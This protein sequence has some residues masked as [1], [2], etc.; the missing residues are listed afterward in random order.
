[1]ST[2]TSRNVLLLLTLAALAGCSMWGDDSPRTVARQEFV[3]QPGAASRPAG[4]TA[5]K[6]GTMTATDRGATT[7]PA[8]P[9]LT[10]D[11]SPRITA[12]DPQ[13][14]DKDRDLIVAGM[15]GQV[16]GQPIY[17]TD[18][19]ESMDEQLRRLGQDLRPAEFERQV[20]EAV[21]KV[22]GEIIFNAL[23]LGEAERDLSPQE[24]QGV[25]YTMQMRREEL[26]RRWGAGSE[27]V[28]DQ[29]LRQRSGLDHGKGL[30][31]TLTEMRQKMLVQRY[32]HIKLF[33]KINITRKDI[34][35]Y[36]ADNQ[37]E[38][39]PKAWRTIRL[40]EVQDEATRN[41]VQQMLQDGEKFAD[42]AA[43]PINSYRSET[44]GLFAEKLPGDK[45]FA[46]KLEVLNDAMAKL[47]AGE[48]AGPMTIGDKD[49]WIYLDAMETGR[50][51]SLREVQREI[52]D[53]IRVQRFQMLTMRYRN[54]LFRTGTYNPMDQMVNALVHIAM[55]RYS[56]PAPSASR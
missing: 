47:K 44:G 38:Y 5:A 7:A 9:A 30:E 16:N 8:S 43:R 2:A 45:V 6:A 39:H 10:D 33:P 55:S 54:E 50:Q 23:I 52:E 48:M 1:M 17:D 14:S 18:V 13:G 46:G 29:A 37:E 56:Q 4:E 19:F 35:R 15:V 36:Y 24:Q 20:R 12:T 26:V 27:L 28:A 41:Q 40:I 42:I 49:Y 31:A 25:G 51:R 21:Q 53:K 34:E 3:R 32:L 11:T 22:L